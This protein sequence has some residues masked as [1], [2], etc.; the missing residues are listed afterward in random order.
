MSLSSQ[1]YLQAALISAIPA[2]LTAAAA[3]YQAKKNR[4]QGH[5]DADKV[6]NNV[7][8]ITEKLNQVDT[9]FERIDTHFER[10]DL[11]LDTIEDKVE[12]HLGWH[13]ASAEAQLPLMLPKEKSNGN[14]SPND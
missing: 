4:Q 8:K 10:L 9:R 7:G 11:R 5:S 1:P 6:L 13:R 3:W 2:T 12:R 14:T